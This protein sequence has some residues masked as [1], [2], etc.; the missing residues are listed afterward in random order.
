MIGS[1]YIEA[2]TL[3]GLIV[4]LEKIVGEEEITNSAVR[5]YVN[6][7]QSV[8]DQDRRSRK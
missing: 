8:A 1:L 3:F 7:S 4:K 6:E 5:K 2:S